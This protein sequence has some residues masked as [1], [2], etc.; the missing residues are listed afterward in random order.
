MLA[1]ERVLSF[2]STAGAGDVVSAAVVAADLD[3][4]SIE[5]TSAFAMQRAAEFLK[6]RNDER[7]IDTLNERN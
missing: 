5:D 3:G 7:L 1:P 6:S 4:K 2:A